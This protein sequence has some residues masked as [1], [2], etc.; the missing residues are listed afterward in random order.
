MCT[1]Y[2][3]FLPIGSGGSGG[4]ETSLLLLLRLGS[5]LVKQLEE[6]GSSVLVKSVGELGNCGGNFEALVKDDLLALE[7]DIFRPFDEASQVALGLDILTYVQR[8]NVNLCNENM[9]QKDDKPMP[10]FL[11]L[12]SKRGFFFVLVGLLE[13]KGLAAGFLEDPALGLG[14]WSLRRSV[15]N[16][17]DKQ[18]VALR[19]SSATHLSMSSPAYTHHCLASQGSASIRGIVQIAD[20]ST[21]E[22]GLQNPD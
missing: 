11:G 2:L 16:Y 15:S 14:G 7:T 6:L 20:P 10:K 8:K 5:I 1:T 9:A 19:S 22:V 13:P 18:T 3:G 4:Q 17:S 21:G 12:D